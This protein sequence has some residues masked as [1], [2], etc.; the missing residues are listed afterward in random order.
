[1]LLHLLLLPTLLALPALLPLPTLLALPTLVAL[2]TLPKSNC[3]K[4][5]IIN[6]DL[7]F[8][9]SFYSPLCV[10]KVQERKKRSHQRKEISGRRKERSGRRRERGQWKRIQGTK[11][12][13]KRLGF[14]FSFNAPRNIFEV[15][16]SQGREE[17]RHVK[18]ERIQEEDKEED[19]DRLSFFVPKFWGK[20]SGGNSK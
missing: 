2:P 12:I 14:P 19:W 9:F 1:M 3:L 13:W 17:R 5:T 10:K 16:R 8:P 4:V 6:K 11:E 18:K 15:M 7:G 20:R